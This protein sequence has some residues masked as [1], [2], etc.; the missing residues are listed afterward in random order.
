MAL[1]SEVVFDVAQQPF[2]TALLVGRYAHQWSPAE[3]IQ[4][5]RYILENLSVTVGAETYLRSESLSYAELQ[6]VKGG[7][8]G[9]N[10]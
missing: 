5:P 2:P 9:Q 1:K 7:Q 3:S 8:M 6:P 4:Q 10:A